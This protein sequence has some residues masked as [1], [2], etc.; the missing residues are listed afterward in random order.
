VLQGTKDLEKGMYHHVKLA[1]RK[2][3]LIVD[4]VVEAYLHT[5]K[6]SIDIKSLE[7][8]EGGDE[9][10]TVVYVHVG[11]GHWDYL[12][13]M[14]LSFNSNGRKCI[15]GSRKGISEGWIELDSRED[16]G[17]CYRWKIRNENLTVSVTSEQ[18]SLF[19]D[20]I[21]IDAV[22]VATEGRFLPS[23]KTNDSLNITVSG[24]DISS[25]SV[26][27]PIRNRLVGIKTHT[28]TKSLSGTDANLHARITYI[29]PNDGNDI[30]NEQRYSEIP[31][32]NGMAT[33]LSITKLIGLG[34]VFSNW[35]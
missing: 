11:A 34:T 27:Y 6:D 12:S 24:G 3:L 10:I 19:T 32:D 15:T 20:E 14:H 29:V 2:T 22:Q 25:E 30:M 13:G 21:E 23:F 28:S 5:M 4:E 9:A 1:S 8:P 31:L 33:F 17:E 18:N 35:G 7:S 26:V 16:L